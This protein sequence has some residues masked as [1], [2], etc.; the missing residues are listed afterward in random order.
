MDPFDSDGEEESIFLQD[1]SDT[2]MFSGDE[3][4]SGAESKTPPKKKGWLEKQRGPNPNCEIAKN[5][6]V[7]I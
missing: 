4:C 2:D 6:T 1:S 7:W 3:V 5:D